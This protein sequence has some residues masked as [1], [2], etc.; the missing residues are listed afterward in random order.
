ML[1]YEYT[2]SVVRKLL[3]NKYRILQSIIDSIV[4]NLVKYTMLP[5][6]DLL[7]LGLTGSNHLLLSIGQH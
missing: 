2:N 3:H 1:V 4:Q 6:D 7:N 5:T